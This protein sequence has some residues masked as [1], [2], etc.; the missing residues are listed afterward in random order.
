M[1]TQNKFFTHWPTL[2]LGFIVAMFFPDCDI[3]IPN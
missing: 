3:F 2:L 1:T